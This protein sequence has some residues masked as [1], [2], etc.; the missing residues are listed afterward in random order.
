MNTPSPLI[1]Q[2][3]LQQS[4]GKS[5]VRIAVFTI[6]AIHVLLLGGLL[7]QGCKRETKTDETV[8]STN[9]ANDVGFAPM[10]NAE[11]AL[12]NPAVSVP[13]NPP[14]VVTPPSNLPSGVNEVPAVATKDYVVVKGDILAAIAKKHG[15]SVKEIEA[16]NPGLVATKLKIGQK[17]QIPASSHPAS[18]NGS[19]ALASTAS[20]ESA[21]SDTTTYTVKPNDSLTKIARTHGTT[22]LAVRKL[23]NLK[24][25]RINVGQKLK[26]PGSRSSTSEAAGAALTNTNYVTP[27]PA[28]SAR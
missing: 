28:S 7:I 24:T 12:S 21:G 20:H 15:V 4:R 18:S 3:S 2:G 13:S 8:A 23:N 22:P 10:T 5:N 16:V 14:V 25:D 17:I 26:I 11:V 19:S 9:A 27:L 1:P 6:L